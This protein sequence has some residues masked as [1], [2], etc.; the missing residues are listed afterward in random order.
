MDIGYVWVINDAEDKMYVPQGTIMVLGQD[1][2]EECSEPV[3]AVRGVREGVGEDE[4]V[5]LKLIIN[6]GVFAEHDMDLKDF[7]AVK[8]VIGTK[9]ARPVK[10][11]PCRTPLAFEGEEKNLFPGVLQSGRP[12]QCWFGSGV[13]LSYIV[14][15]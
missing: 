8:H 1:W 11:R 15:I 7:S 13:A 9:D 5:A 6:R 3:G 10:Q 2:V 14:L 12:L 4:A